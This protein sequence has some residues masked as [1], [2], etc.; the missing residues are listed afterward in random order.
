MRFTR[1]P[2][3]G[4]WVV[5]PDLLEDERGFFARSWDPQEFDRHGLDPT[6]AQCNIS[7]NRRKGT[8]R[9]LHYQAAPVPDPKLVRCTRGAI[10]D[11]A[12]DLRRDSPTFGKSFATVLSQ[13][14]HLALFIPGGLAHGFQTLQDDTEVLYQMG[15]PY[16]A[17]L[18]R[19]VRWDDPAFALRWPLPDP[20]LSARDRSFPDHRP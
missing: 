11:V 13:D 16:V 12:L 5:E 2:L 9:G 19:G 15:A 6:V 18:S 14:N 7:Y 8:L 4:V 20:T 10:H 3:D 17:D 1:T